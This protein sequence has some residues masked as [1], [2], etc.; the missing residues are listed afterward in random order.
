MQ[1]YLPRISQELLV[2]HRLSLNVYNLNLGNNQIQSRIRLRQ[3][4]CTWINPISCLI[5]IQSKK[6]LH[7]HSR[8]LNYCMVYYM[9]QLPD[10]FLAVGLKT[11]LQSH[12][13]KG[14]IRIQVQ[15]ISPSASLAQIMITSRG[16][17]FFA[18]EALHV[19]SVNIWIVMAIWSRTLMS[20]LHIDANRNHLQH[21]D[22]K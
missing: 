8:A 20:P 5:N 11:K 1:S 10:L 21:N 4:K 12:A 7:F 3:V 16:E 6:P 18:A 15:K 9:Q 19:K 2:F 17:F 14:Q 13:V 22:L